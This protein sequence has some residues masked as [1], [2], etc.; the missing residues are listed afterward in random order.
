MGWGNGGQGTS[1]QRSFTLGLESSAICPVKAQG[2]P[3]FR[4]ATARRISF[5]GIFCS[6]SIALSLKLPD[7]SDWLLGQ[8]CY[9]QAKATLKMD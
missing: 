7:S 2:T 4:A 1:S 5:F 3:G 8:Q 6:G 9:I